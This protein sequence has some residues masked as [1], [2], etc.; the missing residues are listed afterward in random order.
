[1]NPN[2]SGIDR[3]KGRQVK[4]RSESIKKYGRMNITP[5]NNRWT[6]I[7]FHLLRRFCIKIFPIRLHFDIFNKF[8]D[9]LHKSIIIYIMN[10]FRIIGHVPH[11]RVRSLSEASCHSA[12]LLL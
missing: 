5:H 11:D 7:L 12:W 9:Y 3:K 4:T 1:M 2:I 10:F 8:S 6:T